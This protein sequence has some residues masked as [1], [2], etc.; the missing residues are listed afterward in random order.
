[1]YCNH[2]PLQ[3]AVYLDNSRLVKLIMDHTC[4]KASAPLKTGDNIIHL[5]VSQ[6]FGDSFILQ[7]L[8]EKLEEETGSKERVKKEFLLQKSETDGLDALEY[9]AGSKIHAPILYKY[10][11]VSGLPEDDMYSV[12]NVLDVDI[13]HNLTVEE[14][15]KCDKKAQADEIR[16]ASKV[17]YKDLMKSTET[18]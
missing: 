6:K 17:T 11:S 2:N 13:I 18:L 16:V 5:M 12:S 1:M 14:E 9:C 7:K 4:Y 15:E 10:S 3:M 8:L